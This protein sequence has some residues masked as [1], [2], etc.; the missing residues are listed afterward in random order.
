MGQRYRR[1]DD[2]QLPSY[3]LPKLSVKMSPL[4]DVLRKV[5]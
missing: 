5:V 3:D 4:G 2:G 1:L